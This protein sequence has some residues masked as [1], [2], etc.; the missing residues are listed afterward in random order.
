M[1]PQ[2]IIRRLIYTAL[3]AS[4]LCTGLDATAADGA[5]VVDFYGYDNC[6]QLKNDSTTAILCP[7]SG[8]RVLS[9]SLN[10]KNVLYLPKGD[11]GWRFDAKTSNAGRASMN[12]GR[13]DIGP[14]KVVKRGPLLWMGE[15]SGE[16]T[17]DRSARLTSQVDTIS[18]V[19]LTRDFRL[20][21]DSSHLICTQ[22]I[23]NVS[24]E[25]VNLCHWSRTFAVGDGIAIVPRSPLGRFPNGWVMYSNGK[26]IIIDPED[27][28]VDVTPDEVI[29][30]SAPKSPKLGFDSMS[31]WL[32]YLAPTDQLFVKRFRT[33]PDR[34]YN[35]V[36]GL[37]ISVW[38][39]KDRPMVEL[40]P[41]GPA[42]M[43]KPGEE[44]S[45]TE[46]WWLLPYEFP[47]SR[48]ANTPELRSIVEQKTSPPR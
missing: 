37:T 10:G 35:E 44:Q 38:Y 28:N 17:G 34:A 20:A 31:G 47:T 2:S 14:E 6:I 29:V 39:P 24:D 12:A 4:L 27:P 9:Y 42:A 19:R 45:F 32:A 3:F 22:T 43:L 16:I 33:H 8:G 30:K 11:E 18:G 15:W 1:L 21:S 13:F 5:S 25:P 48:N 7:A 26:N 23:D 41:I 40:E 46:E 36:A